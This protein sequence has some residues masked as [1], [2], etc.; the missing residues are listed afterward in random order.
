[1]NKLAETEKGGAVYAPPL[2]F[3]QSAADL[4]HGSERADLVRR[5]AVEAQVTGGTDFAGV[6]A[7]STVG[8]EPHPA[9]DGAGNFE[10]Y[11]LGYGILRRLRGKSRNVV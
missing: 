2:W 9:A 7:A 4:N 3:G 8:T 11:V 10:P 6:I 5:A 1:M